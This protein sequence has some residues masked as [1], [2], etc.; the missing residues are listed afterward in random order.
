M[1]DAPISNLT[2]TNN[3]LGAVIQSPNLNSKGKP[4]QRSIRDA[5]MAREVIKTV[6]AA[7]RNRSIV[8]SRILAK[9][10]AERPYDA[11]K[12]EAEGL[13]WRSNFTTKPLPSM[14]EKVAPRF[15]SVIDGLK[16]FTSASLGN[17]WQGSQEKTDAFRAQ[18]TKTIRSR[19]GWRTLIEDIAF[20]N[21]LFGHTIVAWMDEFT[22]FPKHFKQDESFVSDGTKADPRWAQVV[23]LKEVYLPHELFAQISP[24][25]EAAENAGWNLA[26]TQSAINRAAPNQVRDRL[27]VG[28]TLE[29][30][31]QNALRE[32]TIGASYMAGNLVIVV[33]SLLAREVTGKVS[34]YRLAGPEMASIFSREDRFPSMEDCAAFFTFQ[35]GNGTLHGSKG[36]G[37]DIYE[38]AGMIDRTRNE[39]V[40]RLIMSGKTMI[41]GD[42]RRIHTFRLSVIGNTV[43]VPSGWDVLERKIDGNV[44]GFLKL[45]GYFSQIINTL[46]GSTSV[47]QPGLGGEDMRSPAAWNL[48]AQREEEGRD[49]RLT[50]FMAQFTDMVQTMQRRICDKETLE[51]D[52]KEAQKLLLEKMTREEI[53]ELAGQPVAE[54]VRDLTPLER[55]LVISVSQE[56]RGNPLYNQR[57]L[58]V[59]DLSARLGADFAG[60]VLLPENDPTEQAEQLRQQQIELTLL[61]HGEPVPVSPR[62]NHLIHLQS[63]MPA[64]E[65]IAGQMMQ[66]Q[67]STE[68]F[69]AVLAHIQEHVTQALRQGIKTDA[70]TSVQSFLKNATAQ[71]AKLKALDQQ[72]AQVSQ[73]NDALTA[74]APPDEIAAA[75]LPPDV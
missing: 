32:L 42:I 56:K 24:D 38:M 14:I 45:D 18:I 44:E 35:K 21:A 46:I 62:D 67:F 48:L 34:H 73:Q 74:G 11:Y 4:T 64:A 71:I 9:Y 10:N 17:K 49:V 2:G 33:Y 47:P 37:R 7:G 20:D 40:D 66:G 36:V 50:R 29:T 69:E 70:L 41:Q 8:N 60:R 12:L 1:A 19:K 53:D 23:I 5:S 68:V 22:W 6:I 16:Y 27:N 63:L 55:Q 59:E 43:V 58:E 39:V 25:R 54:T 3:D 51:E 61:G 72:A 57:Q 52:A 28:G 13:G 26:E 30:W 65:Q 31:Y 15:V 75:G